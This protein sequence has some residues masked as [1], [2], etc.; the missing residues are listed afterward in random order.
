VDYF[1]IG[2]ATNNGKSEL[3]LSVWKEGSFYP[4]KPFWVEEEDTCIKNHLFI[5]QF[6]RNGLKPIILALLKF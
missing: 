1:F 6:E 2:D 4:Y 3:S 5:F